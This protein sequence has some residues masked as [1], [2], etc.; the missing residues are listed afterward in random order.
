MKKSKLLF[1]LFFLFIIF[2]S[3]L[4]QAQY[5]KLLDF[6]GITNGSNP[7]GSLFFDG[8][9]LYG[10][11]SSGGTKNDGTVFKIKPDGFGFRNL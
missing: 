11:T 1:P 10:T 6:S 4:I 3:S 8:T 2:S 5:S 7:K 9:F